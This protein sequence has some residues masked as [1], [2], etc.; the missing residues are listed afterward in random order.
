M[1]CTSIATTTSTA[2]SSSMSNPTN[3]TSSLS[4][5]SPGTSSSTLSSTASP[6]PSTAS[7]VSST[8]SQVSST[9]SPV[10]PNCACFCNDLKSLCRNFSTDPEFANLTSD[11]ILEKLIVQLRVNKSTLS[12]TVRKKTSATDNRPSSVSIGVVAAVFLTTE[13]ALF[14]IGDVAQLAVYVYHKIQ[15]LIL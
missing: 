6:V 9:A 3:S 8:A 4:S 5:T 12:A 14:V 11:E 15:A 7:P 10:S 13:F 2:S 1:G